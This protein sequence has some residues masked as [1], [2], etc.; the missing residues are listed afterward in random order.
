MLEFDDTLVFKTLFKLLNHDTRNTFVKLNALISELDQTPVK[1]MIS[2]SIQELYDLIAS[3]AGF[4]DGKKRIMSMY[5][6]VSELS[7]TSSKITLTNHHRVK[8]SHDPKIYLFVEVSEL[9]NHAILNLVENALKYSGENEIVDV[10]I[11]REGNFISVY[12]K[13]NGMGISDKDKERIFEQGYRTISALEQQGTGTGLWIT[14]NI[15]HKDSGTIEVYD[16]KPKGSVFKVSVP[17]FF[18]SSLEDSMDIVVNNYLDDPKELNECIRS[19][20]TLI[21]LH[22]PPIEYHY[23]SLLFANL[24]NY[25]RKEKRNKTQSHFKDKLLEIKS[26]NPGGKTVVIVDDSTYVHYYLGTFFSELGYRVVDF[27]FNGLEGF[28]LYETH[29]PDLI[30]LDITM[31]VMSGVEASEKILKLNPGANL[32]FLS[33]LGSHSGLIQTL[34]KKLNGRTYGILTKP[35][36]KEELENSL[37]VFNF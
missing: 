18:T 26:K 35:F 4:I 1:D 29:N 13:D 3:S 11:R 17:I 15:V 7:L 33:G 30:T 27:A 25:L 5:D 24:L 34:D 28:N 22:E 9:F 14:K 36:S 20:K 10:S 2:D 32:L 23:D 16:N 8:F 21:D 37:E 12:V 6:I 19:I 31:P